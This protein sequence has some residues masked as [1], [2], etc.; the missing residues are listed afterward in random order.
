MNQKLWQAWIS[1]KDW[2]RKLFES[3]A[4]AVI[5]DFENHE[6]P[7][8]GTMPYTGDTHDKGD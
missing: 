6:P 7:E 3:E 1:V 4:E 8:I 5:D 2:F